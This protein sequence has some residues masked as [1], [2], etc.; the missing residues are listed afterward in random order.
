MVSL[1][2]GYR[3]SPNEEAAL[4]QKE[5]DKRRKQRLQQ[6]REQ[7]KLFARQ[8]RNAVSK[9]K[10]EE[11]KVLGSQLRENWLREQRNKIE[12]LQKLYS[13]NLR[14]IGQGHK[15]ASEQKPTDIE[16]TITSIHNN[17]KA[18]ERYSVALDN[19]HKKQ[20]AQWQREN[21]HIMARKTAL[22]AERIRAAEIAKLPPPEKAWNLDDG[23]EVHTV[24]LTSETG[25]STTHYHVTAGYAEKASTHQQVHK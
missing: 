6:V 23:P 20:D 13:C 25:L 21:S 4:I 15:E 1:G 11:V 3:L 18:E 2:R 16:R 24:K 17:R 19:L 7:E 9:K 22:E 5:K 8:L 12:A 14:S 10:E